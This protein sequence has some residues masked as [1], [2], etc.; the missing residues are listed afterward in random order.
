MW[1][2][3]SGVIRKVGHESSS[4]SLIF[5]S[6]AS[7]RSFSLMLFPFTPRPPVQGRQG[8]FLFHLSVQATPNGDLGRAGPGRAGPA[9]SGRHLWRRRRRC[10]S[11]RGCESCWW[12]SASVDGTFRWACLCGGCLRATFSIPTWLPCGTLRA[13]GVLAPWSWLWWSCCC[14][15]RVS[16]CLHITLDRGHRTH[17][18]QTAAIIWIGHSTPASTLTQTGILAVE[19][20]TPGQGSHA[21]VAPLAPAG[22]TILLLQ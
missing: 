5:A 2:S 9:D 12:C 17:A 15:W 1:R 21:I 18:R 22:G 11:V 16:I 4:C 6:P 13:I 3:S 14:C 8:S 10:C 7:N 19:N 20:R